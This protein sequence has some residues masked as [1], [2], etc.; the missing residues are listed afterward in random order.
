MK[1]PGIFFWLL[2][3]VA[4]LLCLVSLAVLVLLVQFIPPSVTAA[5][6]ACLTLAVLWFFLVRRRGATVT[7]SETSLMGRQSSKEGLL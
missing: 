5:A 7:G 6:V 3:P 4:V 1:R 2:L